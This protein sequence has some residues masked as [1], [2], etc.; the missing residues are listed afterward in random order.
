MEFHFLD[1]F[2][3]MAPPAGGDVLKMAS[4]PGV[5]PFSA[6]NPSAETFP[7]KE[8]EQVTKELFARQGAAAL[9]Q[10]GLSEGYGPL[11]EL[12][13]NRMVGKHGTGREFDQLMV[14]SG[15]QQVIQLFTRLMVEAGDAVIV[16]EPTFMGALNTFRSAGARI[17]PVPMEPDGMDLDRLENLLKEE[18]QIKF[19]YVITTFQNPTGFSTSMEKRKAI[20]QLAQKYDVMI[21]EDN[22]YFELRIS[23]EY[24]PPLK[25]LDEEGRVIFA[26]SLSKILSP[27]VRLGYAQAHKDVIAR[28]TMLK[29]AGDVHSNLFFQAVA[30]EYFAR[31]DLDAHI[32][33][34]T[35]LYKEKR[36]RMLSLL[37]KNLPE[38]VTFSRPE[39][40]LFVW[41][42]L[43]EGLDGTDLAARCAQNKVAVVPG[44]VFL[45]DSTQ[46][47]A[48]V[49]LNYSTPSHEQIDRG[50]EI[51]AGCVREI[52]G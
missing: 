5:I 18:K 16:E 3:Q 28:M 21:L 9:F 20:Y 35:A 32:S 40:G 39:G 7:L 31:Y 27:G 43:P 19:I 44:A 22:P 25:S 41:L 4:A 17:R 38:G 8:M 2:Q 24:Q 36:D 23:G 12:L 47:S 13:Q 46:V 37:E 10:Y 42:Q 1:R 6:G 26:G 33:A 29:Q 34:C 45:A 48:G 51:L 30:A 15:G 14:T 52:M 11:R 50:V 49:R